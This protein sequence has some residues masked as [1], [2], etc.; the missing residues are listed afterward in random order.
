MRYGQLRATEEEIL[1]ASKMANAHDFILALPNGYQ[2][3]IGERGMR[4]SGG[5]KQRL[6]IARAILKGSNVL[7]LDEATSFL[8]SESEESIRK[9]LFKLKD[10]KTIIVIA[11]KLSTI[12]QSDCILVLDSGKIV[13]QGTHALLY[14]NSAVYRDIFDQQLFLSKNENHYQGVHEI[15]EGGG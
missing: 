12:I 8:D 2:T 14:V 9:A 3:I 11:H 10:E 5:Q 13:S 4:L 1:F 6:D 7:I 15:I